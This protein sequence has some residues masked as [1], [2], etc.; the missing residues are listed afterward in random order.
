MLRDAVSRAANVERNGGHEWVKTRRA[1]LLLRQ[2]RG[3]IER[4]TCRYHGL[5]CA[6]YLY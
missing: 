2:E 3:D 5:H 4:Y 1:G 6:C